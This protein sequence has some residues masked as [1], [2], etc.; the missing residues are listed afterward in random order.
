MI[1]H[2]TRRWCR[3]FAGDRGI[4]DARLK[5][6]INER[7]FAFLTLLVSLIPIMAVSSSFV[8][9]FADAAISGDGRQLQ[10]PIVH[11]YRIGEEIG[12]G[13]FSKYAPFLVSALC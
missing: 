1:T 12:G 2:L 8:T 4:A 10:Y 6:E 9:Q 7:D 13:G 11:G 3:W 5:D